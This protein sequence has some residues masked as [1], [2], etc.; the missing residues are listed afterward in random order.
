MALGRFARSS[1]PPSGPATS[2]SSRTARAA[3]P[4]SSDLV[5]GRPTTIRLAPAAMASAGVATRAWSSADADERAGRTPGQM[6]S[7]EGPSWARR[8]ATSRGEQTIAGQPELTEGRI[9]IP[10]LDEKSE[11]R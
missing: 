7:T 6:S 3:P 9:D 1:P 4:T 11:E 8:A 10:L 5:I 2:A